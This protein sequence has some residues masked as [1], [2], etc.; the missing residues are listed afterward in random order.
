[1]DFKLPRN[2]P[3]LTSQSEPGVQARDLVDERFEATSQMIA[4]AKQD[5]DDAILELRNSLSPIVV[6]NLSAS[7]IVVPDLGSDI[8]DFTGVFNATFSATLAVFEVSYVEPTGKPGSSPEWVDGTISLNDEF[9]NKVAYWLL[10]GE[11]AIP[12]TIID[13][14]WNAASTRIDEQRSAAILKAESDVAARNFPYPSGIVSAQIAQIEREFGKALADQSASLAGKVAELTQQNFHKACELALGYINAA[15]DYNVKR[16]S[17]K[18]QAYSVAADVWIK[19]VEAAIKV[20][21]AKVSAFNGQVQAY[22]AKASV[23]KTEADVY[24]SAVR[25]YIAMVEGVKAK[26]DAVATSVRMQVE[27]FQAETGMAIEEEKLR[28]E[29]QV[30]QM[31][32][33]ERIAEANAQ[34]NGQV[35]SSAL[36][37]TH[38]QAAISAQHDTG[39]RV[40][41]SY[42]YQEDYNE[43]QQLNQNLMQK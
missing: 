6:Q 30:Q 4:D 8:P 28:V 26:I 7:G 12:Q 14:I 25:A 22:Q 10:N 16:N 2:I 39:Q 40:S 34:L 27:V 13:Q 37:A 15:Q 29:A 20:I 33:A 36:S 21:D 9:V 38:V 5:F 19:Q 18:M 35:L 32:L 43:H 41:F 31:N 11:T 23:Y 42:Q 3:W 17:A 1:M 24:D